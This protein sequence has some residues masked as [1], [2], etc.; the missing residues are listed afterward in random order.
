MVRDY[1][2]EQLGPGHRAAHGPLGGV[3]RPRRKVR[4]ARLLERFAHSGDGITRHHGDS[5]V[6]Q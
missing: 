1:L 3:E 6:A 2:E 4:F 5:A